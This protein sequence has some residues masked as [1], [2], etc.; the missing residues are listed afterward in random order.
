MH[1]IIGVWGCCLDSSGSRYSLMEVG[2]WD[3]CNEISDSINDEIFFYKF[4]KN[5]LLKECSLWYSS[6]IQCCSWS[7][8]KRA[9]CFSIYSYVAY[10]L[11][12][13]DTFSRVLC[14]NN[15]LIWSTFMWRFGK[16][17]KTHVVKTKDTSAFMWGGLIGQKMPAIL[18]GRW[19]QHVL[20]AVSECK[21]KS[22][23][24]YRYGQTT[25]RVGDVTVLGNW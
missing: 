23:W 14:G 21:T 16:K 10:S 1:H 12:W 24:M 5:L 20:F 7:L 11:E 18:Y 8:S 3:Q 17:Y 25:W 6:N 19:E 4:S 15:N 22:E 9:I 2:F 13:G